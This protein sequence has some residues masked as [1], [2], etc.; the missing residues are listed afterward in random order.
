M[1]KDTQIIA[2]MAKNPD[3]GFGMLM[4][5][6]REPVYWHIRRLVVSHDD[7]LD[8]TQETFL[9]VFRAFDQFN[10]KYSL[11][12]WVFHIAT[13]EALRLLGRNQGRITVSLDEPTAEIL[14]LKADNY[15]DYSDKL[16]VKLQQAIHALPVK[17]QLAFNMQES[18]EMEQITG[19]LRLN[20]QISGIT[21]I[22]LESVD[23]YALAGTGTIVTVNGQKNI[24]EI[25]DPQSIITFRAPAN[26]T[27]VT[28]K[29]YYITTFPCDVYGGYRLSIY[30]DGLVAH[31]FGVHQQF[32][33]GNYIAPFD[34]VES[35][36]DFVDPAEPL[37]EDERPGLSPATH[38]A[39]VRYRQ[40]PTAENRELLLEQMG[41]RYDK[42]VAR[43]KAKLRQ[44]EREAHDQ[45]LIDE[46]QAIVD[47]M[48]A[49]RDV[50]IWQQ[51]LRL[52]AIASRPKRNGSWRRV[53]CPKM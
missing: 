9:R 23:G 16:T 29:D 22:E 7:A 25:S 1:S 45:H 51:F 41:I 14:N 15:F 10:T 38:Q 37:V 33:A 11:K 3:K 18:Y 44:L 53:T 36:L 40:N 26:G 13:N 24:S 28:G 8:V 48:V 4:K 2:A 5:E 52:I 43:K 39:L 49:N 19:G 50:R 31:F 17:Q 27:L 20:F 47:E 46:M 30:K 6:Y 21:H 34:L 32:E 35:E 42:V 12:T